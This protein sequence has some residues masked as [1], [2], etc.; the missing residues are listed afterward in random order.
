LRNWETGKPIN[1]I[2]VIDKPEG[3]SSFGAVKRIQSLT[4]VRKA[5]HT[6]TLDPLAT[7]VLP[8]CLNEATKIVRFLI[9]QDKEY[10]AVMTLG[11]ETDTGDREGRI[12][13]ERAVP[14]LSRS[15]VEKTL[16]CFIGKI[17]QTPPP[18]SAKKKNGVPLYRMARKG[19]RI[20]VDPVEVTIF[21]LEL[22][23]LRLPHISFDLQ[24][25][26]GTYI[27]TLAS[28]IGHKLG[29]GGHLR[30]LR[31]TCCGPF[32]LNRS[33]SLDQF[34]ENWKAG[35]P[36]GGFWSIEEA[37]EGWPSI[38]L[39]G[40][41]LRKVGHGI[42]LLGS[43]LSRLGSMTFKKGDFVGL[44]SSEGRLIAV[45]KAIDAPL[46]EGENNLDRP[47]VRPVRLLFQ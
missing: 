31:R 41:S 34:G 10:S 17:S 7:G 5:G 22:R 8:I 38:V 14:A 26:K 47:I 1:G 4:R 19:F 30:A 39:D 45:G 23:D 13:K 2:V 46:P 37:F 43:D 40:D 44:L 24:C 35:M 36:G 6:G 18:F 33:C 21:D 11:V 15:E 16:K 3:I 32:K 20:E 42:P 9:D 29:C 28:D 12:I 25:S 27:R